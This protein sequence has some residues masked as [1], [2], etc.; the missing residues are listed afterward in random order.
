MARA[1][2]YQFEDNTGREHHVKVSSAVGGGY[3]G[4]NVRF[5]ELG[6]M[7]HIEA[8][9]ICTGSKEP[10]VIINRAWDRLTHDS[11]HFKN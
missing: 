2:N 7:V 11:K 5:V 9:S 8:R 4:W 3:D 6:K 1:T 10:N